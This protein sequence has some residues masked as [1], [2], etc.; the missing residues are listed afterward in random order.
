M[1]V[2]THSDR[3]APAR[4]NRGDSNLALASQHADL[5]GSTLMNRSDNAIYAQAQSRTDMAELSQKHNFPPSEHLLPAG[6]STGDV[7]PPSPYNSKRDAT[8]PMPSAGADASAATPPENHAAAKPDDNAPAPPKEEGGSH[9]VYDRPV[10]S[11]IGNDTKVA[12]DVAPTSV[13]ADTPSTGTTSPVENVD[14][15][16]AAPAPVHQ[17][18][19]ATPPA[20]AQ[21]DQP[22]FTPPARTD[23]V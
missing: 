20:N 6:Q 13:P 2:A 4:D 11:T 8:S 7:A 15:R 3:S 9:E 5:S 23:V 22:R 1:A 14:S 17:H 12:V 16:A 18:F 10:V 19:D 21:N